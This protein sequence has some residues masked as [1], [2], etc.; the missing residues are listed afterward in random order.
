MRTLARGAAI[1]SLSIVALLFVV[2]CSSQE[3]S[4]DALECRN[5]VAL[6]APTEPA[7]DLRLGPLRLQAGRKGTF[8]KGRPYKVG[9]TRDVGNET[10][11]VRGWDCDG[12]KPLRFSYRQPIAGG[13]RFTASQL[14][15][16]GDLVAEFAPHDPAIGQDKMIYTGYMLFWK[17]GNWKLEAR[18]DDEVV[19]ELVLNLA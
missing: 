2:S 16:K 13:T 14:Q 19:D 6:A 5:A 17:T 7:R 9:V 11:R 3:P 18:V 1:D 10:I 15:R 12:G 8:E 4:A